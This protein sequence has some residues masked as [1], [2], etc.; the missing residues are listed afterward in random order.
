MQFLRCSYSTLYPRYKFSVGGSNAVPMSNYSSL[1]PCYKFSTDSSNAVPVLKSFYTLPRYKFSTD[2]SNAV[3]LL[4]L[5]YTFPRYKFPTV[6]FLCCSSYP[7]I[8]FLLTVPM[9]FLWCKYS[10][11]YSRNKFLLS[12]SLQILCCFTHSPAISI[13]LTIPVLQLFYIV[14]RYK[15]STDSSNAVTLC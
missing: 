8:S 15:F 4:Q 2:S 6:S 3:T 1:Y 14:P 9:R 13:L 12:V 5:F 11:H 7:A 10:T